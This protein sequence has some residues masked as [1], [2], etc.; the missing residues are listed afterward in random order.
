MLEFFPSLNHVFR[1][2][3]ARSENQEPN[4]VESVTINAALKDPDRAALLSRGRLLEYLTI[5]WNAFEALVSLVAGWL[6][7]SVALVGF[8]FDSLIETASAAILLWR[9]R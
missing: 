7:G 6:A 1:M 4:F 2:T 8:G 3:I 9:L 5:A